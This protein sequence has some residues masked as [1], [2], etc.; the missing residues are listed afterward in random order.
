VYAQGKDLRQKVGGLGCCLKR[1]QRTYI[2]RYQDM[3]F[4]TIFKV[5]GHTYDVIGNEQSVW[6]L[7]IPLLHYTFIVS[8][9]PEVLFS[10]VFGRR[11]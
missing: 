10:I 3:E 5:H 4:H 7:P 9:Y 11:D 6:W 8:S 2:H 1:G